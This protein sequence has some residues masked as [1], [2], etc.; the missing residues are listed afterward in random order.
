[1]AQLFLGAV[2]Q[3][4][5]DVLR[6]NTLNGGDLLGVD[7]AL[8]DS[9]RLRLPSQLGIGDLIAV[10]AEL[11]G[12]VDAQQEVGMAPP[13]AVEEGPLVD[14]VDTLVHGGEGLGVCLGEAGDGALRERELDHAA[15]APSQGSQ[16]ASFVL[17]SSPGQNLEFR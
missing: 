8:E 7:T 9:R 10:G 14:D 16:M 1:Q 12:A 5:R 4:Q 17:E 2:A 6:L 3:D 11:A 15:M 13:A